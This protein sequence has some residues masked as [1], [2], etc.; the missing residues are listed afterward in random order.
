MFK[1]VLGADRY[2]D[3]RGRILKPTP[4][5]KQERYYD[6]IRRDFFQSTRSMEES[7]NLYRTRQDN[8]VEIDQPL[9]LISQAA[10]SGGTLLKRLFDHHF[11]CHVYPVE[12]LM[13]MQPDLYEYNWPVLDLKA[14]P[15]TW[16]TSL[17]SIHIWRW[18]KDSFRYKLTD[19]VKYP[20]IILPLLMKEIFLARVSH[21]GNATQ[22]AV[23][24]SYM[25]AF[26]N[27]WIDNQNLYSKPKKYTV[28][29]APNMSLQTENI[30]RFFDTYTNGIFISIV[31]DPRNWFASAQRYNSQVYA[32]LT[33]SIEDHWIASAQ[34]ILWAQEHYGDRVVVLRFEELVTDTERT[35]KWLADRFNLTFMPTMLQPTFN[36]LPIRPNSSF[37]S[38]SFEISKSSME[39]YKQ[40]LSAS[41][42][43]QIDK[44]T[45][46]VLE[47]VLASLRLQRTRHAS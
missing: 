20:L 44:M 32:D 28:A 46:P 40:E 25:T 5:R 16:L 30:K 4:Q 18:L 45:E 23:F 27:A 37:S 7:Q 6:Q 38:Q 9:I 22:R 11:Q 21:S 42:I 14:A 3:W 43:A 10:R 12:L 13:G 8:L 17:T 19:D 41:E 33:D 31:R 34:S 39:R 15:E 36:S 35:M 47:D 1:A 29:F 26:F 2:K 24:D